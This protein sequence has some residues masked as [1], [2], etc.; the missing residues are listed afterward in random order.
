MVY[1]EYGTKEAEYFSSR[2]VDG[3]FAKVC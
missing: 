1:F 2:D 3:I